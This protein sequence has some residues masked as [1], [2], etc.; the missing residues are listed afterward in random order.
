MRR[1]FLGLESYSPYLDRS[2]EDYAIHDAGD[3]ELP[4]AQSEET[5]SQIEAF[6]S[7][8][9]AHDKQTAMLGGEHLLSLASIKAFY[10]KYPD[11][12]VVH[13]D[14]HTDLREAYL[15]NP[16][17][18]A[19]VMRRVWELLGDQRIHQLGIRSGEKEEFLF[20]KSHLSI[21]PFDV[22]SMDTVAQKLQSMDVPVYISLDL[23]VLDPSVFP[24]TGTPEPGGISFRSLQDALMKLRDLTSLALISWSFLPTM[25]HRCV[26]SCGMQTPAEMILAFAP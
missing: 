8:C 21:E 22:Q 20:A 5:L 7:T 23:D 1:D 19:S 11:L 4:F 6:V 15:G 16:L 3:L 25:I 18:H 26:D 14:A 12:H 13:L 9:L 2:I 24:G 10:Q 17:S